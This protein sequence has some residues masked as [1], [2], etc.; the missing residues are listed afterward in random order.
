MARIR[1][2]KPEFWSSEQVMSCRPM[3]RLLFI[4]IWN[5]CDDGGNHPLSPRTIKALVFPGDDITAEEVSSLLGELEGANLTLPVVNARSTR[6][7]SRS[8]TPQSYRWAQTRLPG[9]TAQVK[10]LAMSRPP[11]GG[12]RRQRLA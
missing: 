7:I 8:G 10:T 5:F 9:Y 4:G 12:T 3:A 6:A 1:T 2:V 11:S